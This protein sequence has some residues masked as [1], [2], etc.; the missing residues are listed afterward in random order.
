MLIRLFGLSIAVNRTSRIL[1]DPS[2]RG[3]PNLCRLSIAMRTCPICQTVVPPTSK[4]CKYEHF[5]QHHPEFKFMRLDGKH[6]YKFKCLICDKKFNGY[7]TL[8]EHHNHTPRQEG[9]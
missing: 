6:G 9:R 4:D 5:Q 3:K 2:D 1:P 7:G 8:I